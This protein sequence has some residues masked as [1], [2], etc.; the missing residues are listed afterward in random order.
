MFIFNVVQSWCFPNIQTK[1]YDKPQQ[2]TQI[3]YPS[4]FF[5]LK[6][7]ILKFNHSSQRPYSLID[8]L[9]SNTVFKTIFFN[10]PALFSIFLART[11]LSQLPNGNNMSHVKT[12]YATQ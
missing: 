7:I 3:S 1:I 5:S 4:K 9:P 12:F 6:Y 2:I 11:P 8:V 10:F